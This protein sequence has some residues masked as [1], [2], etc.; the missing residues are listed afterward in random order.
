[1]QRL[2]LAALA[3]GLVL[4]PAFVLAFV[5]L[6]PLVLCLGLVYPVPLGLMEEVHLGGEL[7]YHHCKGQD[8]AVE[9]IA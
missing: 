5:S 8:G 1:M 3:F 7:A 6:L 9:R 2:R 4:V